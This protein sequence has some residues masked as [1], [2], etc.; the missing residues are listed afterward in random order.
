MSKRTESATGGIGFGGALTLL[1]VALKLLHQ[2]DWSWWWVLCAFW[3]PI[4]LIAAIGAV[5]FLF[6]LLKWAVGK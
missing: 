5:C 6:V 1:F 3:G 2:I 4:V